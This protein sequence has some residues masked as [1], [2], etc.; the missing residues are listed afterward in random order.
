MHLNGIMKRS[1]SCLIL[2]CERARAALVRHL[3][4]SE[5][6]RQITVKSHA[7]RNSSPKAEPWPIFHFC[8]QS[9]ETFVSCTS[10]RPS[11]SE[12]EEQSRWLRRINT[13]RVL[14]GWKLRF[15]PEHPTSAVKMWT[16]SCF[17][18]KTHIPRGEEAVL[19]HSG[20]PGFAGELTQTLGNRSHNLLDVRQHSMLYS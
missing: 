9:R 5:R 4:L 1:A 12:A 19:L 20:L 6:H 13:N 2:W 16:V 18:E 15:Y 11:S 3:L 10:Q 8:L 17:W 7:G 14:P